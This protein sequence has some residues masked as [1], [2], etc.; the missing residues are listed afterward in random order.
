ML[1]YAKNVYDKMVTQNLKRE[2]IEIKKFLH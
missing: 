2:H 1:R